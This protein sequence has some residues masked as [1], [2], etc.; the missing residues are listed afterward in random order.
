V[1]FEDPPAD[2]PRDDRIVVGMMR[3]AVTMQSLPWE[4]AESNLELLR[5]GLVAVDA[6]WAST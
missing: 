5:V 6:R 4:E 3:S 2:G 1:R